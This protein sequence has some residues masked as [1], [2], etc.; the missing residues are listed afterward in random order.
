MRVVEVTPVP[1][2][3]ESDR[4][5]VDEAIRSQPALAGQNLALYKVSCSEPEGVRRYLAPLA[6]IRVGDEVVPVVTN[7]SL[8][9]G[10]LT[11]DSDGRRLLV[12]VEALR[13]A[14]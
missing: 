1:S 12:V 14:A 6:D 5:L 9:V 2:L 8:T 11:L 7:W 10:R 13:K 3:D 4:K